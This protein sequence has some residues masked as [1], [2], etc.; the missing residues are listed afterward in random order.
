MQAATAVQALFDL[1]PT[2]WQET[3]RPQLE[4]TV[5]GS[6]DRE[7]LRERLSF[8]ADALPWGGVCEGPTA[9]SWM[10][11]M[12]QVTHHCTCFSFCPTHGKMCE[13]RAL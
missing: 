1:L 4:A 9:R 6:R 3:A 5:L 11:S 12:H 13:Q 10:L 2:A 8:L 7:I